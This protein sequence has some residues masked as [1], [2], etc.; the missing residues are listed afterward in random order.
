M[1][2]SILW[3]S[4][5]DVVDNQ[6][7][8]D[9]CQAGI[10]LPEGT[11]L[12]MLPLDF[13]SLIISLAHCISW[14]VCYVDQRVWGDIHSYHLVIMLFLNGIWFIKITSF[15]YNLCNR[16]LVR[17]HFR[18]C[19]LTFSS[20][21]YITEPWQPYQ[22]SARA[23]LEQFH[24]TPWS[25]C[26]KVVSELKSLFKWKGGL[27]PLSIILPSG[28]FSILFTCV[29]FLI[30]FSE[31]YKPFSPKTPIFVGAVLW[32]SIISE[33]T[34]SSVITGAHIKMHLQITEWAW[35]GVLFVKK[36]SACLHYCCTPGFP[37]HV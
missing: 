35:P 5:D 11:Y 4:A 17:C 10:C 34:Y 31:W 2:Y 1:L 28:V 33:T 36:L 32:P 24:H 12:W 27:V 25:S 15:L 9:Q 16:T 26:W 7:L 14:S 20:S 37:G 19:W 13:A 30:H 21:P 29:S 6:C 22:S 8:L 23:S 18:L 3:N